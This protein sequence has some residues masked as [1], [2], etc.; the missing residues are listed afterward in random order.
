MTNTSDTSSLKYDEIPENSKIRA[1]KYLTIQGGA[2][3]D[4]AMVGAIEELENSGVLD[5]IEEVAGCSAGAIFA[6]LVALGYRSKE[7]RQEMMLLN[8]MTLQD[9]E[10]PGWIESS[11]LKELFLHGGFQSLNES[12]KIAAL[13]KLPVVK[14]LIAVTKV[15]GR[16]VGGAESLE[17]L[18]EAVFGKDLGLWT[19]EVLMDLMSRLITRK[20]GNP[21]LTFGEL[22]ILAKKKVGKFSALSLKGVN[23]TKNEKET[24]NAR[25]WPDL[26]I[27]D[28][29]SISTRFPGGYRP[30]IKPLTPKEKKEFED[31]DPNKR[32]VQVR[33]DG[34]LVELLPNEFNEPPYHTPTEEEPS[35]PEVLALSFKEEVHKKSPKFKTG[36]DYAKELFSSIFAEHDNKNKYGDRIIYINSKDIGALEFDASKEKRIALVNSGAES[37]R[38]QFRKILRDE[39]NKK[40]D[41]AEMNANELVRHKVA[42]QY[43]V[44]QKKNLTRSKQFIDVKDALDEEPM[45]ADLRKID[46]LLRETELSDSILEE[47]AIIEMM[48]LDRRLKASEKVEYSD[49]ELVVQCEQRKEELGRVIEELKQKRRQLK[50]VKQAFDYRMAE[51]TTRFRDLAFKDDFIKKLVAI[52]EFQNLIKVNRDEKIKLEIQKSAVP[53]LMSKAAAHLQF[54]GR[55]QARIQKKIENLENEY[56]ALL[57]QKALY[58]KGTL[59]QL[60]HPLYGQRDE[61]MYHFFQELQYDSQDVNSVIPLN[62]EEILKYY[63]KQVKTCKEFIQESSA[64]IDKYKQERI[65]FESSVRTFSRKTRLVADYET[66]KT[67]KTEL[68]AS[69]YQKTGL[70]GKI[71]SYLLD[72]NPRI[73]NVVTALLQCVAFCA[74][75]LRVFLVI[76][77]IS[78]GV[79]HI[80]RRFSS[81]DS[82]LRAASDRVLEAFRMRNLFKFNKMMELQRVVNHFSKII[83]K[84]YIIEDESMHSHLYKLL[85]YH[86]KN[87]GVKVEELFPK[88]V[89]ETDQD[90]R[91]RIKLLKKK[92]GLIEPNI[93]LLSESKPAKAFQN[94][95]AQM[96]K[97]VSYELVKEE[98]KLDEDKGLS[99]SQ[100]QRMQAEQNARKH[101]LRTIHKEFIRNANEKLEKGFELSKSELE[102]YV[103]SARKLDKLIP[104]IVKQQYMHLIDKKMELLLKHHLIVEKEKGLSETEMKNYRRF[105]R[106]LNVE[107]GT[108]IRA[109]FAKWQHKEV[110]RGKKEYKAHDHKENKSREERK[111]TLHES[112]TQGLEYFKRKQ[113]GK[114]AATAKIHKKKKHTHIDNDNELIMNPT[115]PRK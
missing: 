68:Q 33:S 80:V 111:G 87:T 40:A 107:I 73:K 12:A 20:S 94:N 83:D 47:M 11:G 61:L 32:V 96:T 98:R 97:K 67:L 53:A 43:M 13:T 52:S 57:H 100:R 44:R 112:L 35:N 34:G 66:L 21:N 49:Q 72:T 1:I 48:R 31:K 7:I 37:V 114:R 58:F 38:K 99:G 103:D 81:T 17:N 108:E 89:D 76:P 8:F 25:N 65:F 45:I 46:Q 54:E 2:M 91:K 9:R 79:A 42:L 27:L 85:S 62:L 106:E 4:I 105:A 55:R 75:I 5:Q 101:N 22:A 3:K 24:Y 64:E 23:L 51:L 113:K 15:P 39:K 115:R 69:I 86:L 36:I 77:L 26:T 93:K 14:Q 92:L 29:M 56:E 50:W 95:F 78:F 88:K 60:N 104:E 63:G 41:F 110:H 71:N 16:L 6:T 59:D 10:Q 30:W 102:N 18:L 74:F 28:A 84:N 109:R 90:Y 82:K 19:G 70:I